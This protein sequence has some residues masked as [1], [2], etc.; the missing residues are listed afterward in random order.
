M[1]Q[2]NTQVWY[3]LCSKW[4]QL[5]KDYVRFDEKPSTAADGSSAKHPTPSTAAA[6]AA[7]AAGG[8]GGVSP[9]KATAAGYVGDVGGVA[10][11]ATERANEHRVAELSLEEGAIQQQVYFEV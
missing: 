8:A 10:K 1:I 7:A 5:W 11:V 4:W 6:A 3:V 2:R 9:A